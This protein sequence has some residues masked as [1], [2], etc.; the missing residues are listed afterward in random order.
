MKFNVTKGQHGHPKLSGSKKG[1]H[2]VYF[3]VNFDLLNKHFGISRTMPGLSEY[4]L[5]NNEDIYNLDALVVYTFRRD[6]SSYFIN[7]YGYSLM[8]DFGRSMLIYNFLL[9]TVYYCEEIV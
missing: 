7:C 6:R 2:Q 5:V 9:Y 1:L 3:Y 4:S 8:D